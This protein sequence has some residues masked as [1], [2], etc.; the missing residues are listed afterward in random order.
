MLPSFMPQNQWPGDS[1]L[2][3]PES[4]NLGT[5]KEQN[6]FM[7]LVKDGRNTLCKR[8]FYNRVL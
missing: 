2:L 1:L 7:I 3:K 8:D 5:V 4:L 6:V